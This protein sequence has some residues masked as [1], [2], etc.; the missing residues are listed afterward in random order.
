LEVAACATE[1]QFDYYAP[2]GCCAVVARRDRP[3]FQLDKQVAAEMLC[4]R[5][6]LGEPPA[7]RAHEPPPTEAE[8]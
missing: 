8:A 6:F 5:D 4:E 7:V 3:E 1:L 2:F